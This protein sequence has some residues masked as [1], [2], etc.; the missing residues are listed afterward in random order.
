MATNSPD[1]S[2]TSDPA[3]DSGDDS[4]PD[5][6]PDSAMPPMSD[7][8]R[9]AIPEALRREPL[10]A[11]EDGVMLVDIVTA[12]SKNTLTVDAVLS[13][14]M[15]GLWLQRAITDSIGMPYPIL[16]QETSLLRD[17]LIGN[18]LRLY[19][20]GLL[21]GVDIDIR[22]CNIVDMVWGVGADAVVTWSASA[23]P[24]LKAL[25]QAKDGGQS[26]FEQCA[27]AETARGR[28]E[29]ADI[30]ENI[31]CMTRKDLKKQL[32]RISETLG[33]FKRQRH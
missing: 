20:D 31:A 14:P 19:Q 28:L 2:Q 33:A 7:W 29:L 6:S 10:L 11:A 17:L 3:G 4:S 8:L 18:T 12:L 32:I 24:Q 1:V 5:S 21:R 16:I 23:A 30:I 15:V 22:L 9:L 27:E 26:E 13:N 25:S